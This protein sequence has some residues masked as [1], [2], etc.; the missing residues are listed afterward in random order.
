MTVKMQEQ[1]SICWFSID[2]SFEREDPGN[3]VDVTHESKNSDNV[4]S[5]ESSG[6]CVVLVTLT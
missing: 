4:I 1:P 3:E 2:L 6:S 5:T